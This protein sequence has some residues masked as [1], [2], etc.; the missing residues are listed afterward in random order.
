M[1]DTSPTAYFA[2][3]TQVL[4]AT[5]VGAKEAGNIDGE[6]LAYCY[7]AIMSMIDRAII[8]S[9]HAQIQDLIREKLLGS[10]ASDYSSKYGLIALQFLLHSKTVA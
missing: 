9:Q 7:A 2:S 10:Q 4:Q 8:Q 6:V 1:K 3:I 5:P